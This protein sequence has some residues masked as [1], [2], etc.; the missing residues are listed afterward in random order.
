M[1]FVLRINQELRLPHLFDNFYHQV[2]R[3]LFQI[4]SA[5]QLSKDITNNKHVSL[6]YQRQ[7]ECFYLASV[8]N[9]F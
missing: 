8:P 5:L 9:H 1:D 6:R 2:Q 3:Q 4:L 7:R